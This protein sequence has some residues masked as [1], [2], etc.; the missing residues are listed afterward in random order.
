MVPEALVSNFYKAASSNDIS[1]LQTAANKFYQ[2]GY[3]VGQLISQLHDHLISL[4]KEKKLADK[5]M[6][7]I[8]IKVAETEKCL[9][10]GAD[11]Q[12]QLLALGSFMMRIIHA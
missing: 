6:A 1:Q 7:M 2:E 12:L 11:E 10:D 8:A 3:S 4:A 5:H 9:L